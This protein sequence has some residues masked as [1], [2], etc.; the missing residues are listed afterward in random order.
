[1]KKHVALRQMD[2]RVGAIDFTLFGGPYT[3]F[4]RTT[5]RM[6]GVKMAE[7]I[8]FPYFV[9]I[10]TE[11]F[12][13][14]SV[15]SMAAGALRVIEASMLGNDF[16]VG[17]RGGIGRT[18]VFFGVMANLM[19]AARVARGDLSPDAV[20]DPVHWVRE[21]YLSYAIETKEQEE[22]VR[23]FP[24]E[25]LLDKVLW[26]SMRDPL[27][28]GEALFMKTSVEPA[29]QAQAKLP[30]YKRFLKKFI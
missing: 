3:D 12:S 25:L 19:F 21:T 5:R 10:P 14:P 2:F 11:D 13:V 20:P 28:Y 17:C 18:G 23:N 26:L 27:G 22:F 6:L 9:S 16:Y 7:E 1:M 29:P 24:V 15:E 4:D 8:Q 30:W